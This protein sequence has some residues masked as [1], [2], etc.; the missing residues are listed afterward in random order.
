MVE[1]I[2]KVQEISKIQTQVANKSVSSVSFEKVLQQ[3]Q[4]KFS[5]HARNRIIMRNIN[6]SEKNI[7]RLNDA[8]KKAENKGARES[9]ILMDSHAFVVSIKNRTVITAIPEENLRENVITNIDSA[10]LLG[11][12]NEKV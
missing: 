1:K 8:V 6:L 11:E 12:E 10:I 3:T 9:L 7:Q 2:N 4:L 5:A